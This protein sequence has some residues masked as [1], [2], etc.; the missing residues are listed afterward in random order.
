MN[1]PAR[2]HITQVATVAVPVTDTDR[3]LGFY[4]GVLGFEV[5]LDAPFAPGQRWV[6]VAPPGAA[7][8]ATTVA[9]VTARDDVPAGV[10]TGIRLA[11][12]DAAADHAA[13]R[14]A[15]VDVDADVMRLPGGV[16]PMFYLRDP[17]G[18]RLV[19]VE[20]G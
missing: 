18:N 9:L 12:A 2:T 15:G 11:T 6:E 20:R 5:R 14:A 8:T 4:A 13:L 16:P 7:G 10:E 19:V 1:T 17:D 3:A